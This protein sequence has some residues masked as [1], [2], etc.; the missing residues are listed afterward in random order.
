M[1]KTRHGLC[2]FVENE[3]GVIQR[4]TN[5]F[6]ARGMNIDTIHTTPVDVKANVSQI[7]ISLLESSKSIELIQKLLMKI[8]IVHEVHHIDIH[9]IEH[10]VYVSQVFHVKDEFTSK[11]KEVLSKYDV[12]HFNVYSNPQIHCIT[13]TEKIIDALIKHIEDIP[14]LVLVK[15]YSIF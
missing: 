12:T 1:S 5:L 8:L 13:G 7:S 3:F 4:V 10:N 15:K 14:S 11:V 2:I 6:S 9:E